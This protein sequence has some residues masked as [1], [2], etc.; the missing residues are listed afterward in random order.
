[1]LV[2][3][4]L[5][6]ALSLAGFSTAEPIP[7]PGQIEAIWPFSHNMNMKFEVFYT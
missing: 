3:P 6:K 7:K 2:L 4:R 1:M 5:P